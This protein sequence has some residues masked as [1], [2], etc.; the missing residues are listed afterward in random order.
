MRA[1]KPTANIKRKARCGTRKGCVVMVSRRVPT[2]A[3]THISSTR[4]RQTKVG[5]CAM[6]QTTDE[7]DQSLV[8]VWHK[9]F[10]CF[11]ISFYTPDR[12]T[13]EQTKSGR[14]SRADSNADSLKRARHS[15]V[16][17][18]ATLFSACVLQ[19]WVLAP[20]AWTGHKSS[21]FLLAWRRFCFLLA[22]VLDCNSV[23]GCS[24]GSR[25]PI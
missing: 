14:H 5:F 23:G 8:A 2:S 4:L 17:C 6:K 7:I 10:G 16:F 19:L 25:Q 3:N 11:T 22:S 15:L 18:L 21:P 24:P 9:G 13:M 20:G 12:C 1:H